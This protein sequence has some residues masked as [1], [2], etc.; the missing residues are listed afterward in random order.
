M[1]VT[2]RDIARK[3]G[4]SVTT[5]SRAL[6]GHDDVNPGTRAQIVS[7]ADELGY[8][9][10]HSARQLQGQ[11][12]QT[13]GFVM[14]GSMTSLDDD[15]SSLLLRSLTAAAGHNH[16]DMLYSSPSETT[17]ELDVYRRMVGGKRVDGM[18]LARTHVDDR[19]IDYLK[20]ANC[21][22]IV[23]GRMGPQ[24]PSDFHFIDVDSEAG[25]AT[26]TQHLI[27]RGHTHIG[28]ILPGERFAFSQ[29]RLAGY[30]QA[31]EASGMPFRPAYCD[32]GNLTFDSGRMAAE[33]LLNQNPQLTAIVGCN[34]WMALGAIEA[35]LSMGRAVGTTFAVTG[36][37]DIPAAS[38]AKIKLTTMRQSI[39]EIGQRL[40]DQLLTIINDD[41][42]MYY[43]QLIQP[44]LVIR[45]SSGG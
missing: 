39:Y 43:Q 19:R 13:I 25:I 45:D 37:D 15:F 6:G 12:T 32:N 24:Q 4:F 11:K 35:A 21:P 41:P 14:S 23:H 5:V 36:Y 40:I 27:A 38:H 22:F 26:V 2:L 1:P 29:Y 10:N 8:H 3:S 18:V 44:E 20:A 42:T 7:I 17:D 9:P 34:D 33:R 31:L 16:H 28:I 30:R